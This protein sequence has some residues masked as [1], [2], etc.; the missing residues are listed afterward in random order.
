MYD[1]F[2]LRR[3]RSSDTM[4]RMVRESRLS[5]DDFMMP[6]FIVPGKG[7]RREIPSMPGV[8]QI[9][10]DQVVKEVQ[11]VAEFRIPGVLLFGTAQK[12][13][14]QASEAYSEQNVVFQAI[15][16]LKSQLLRVVIAADVCLCAY[17]SHGHCGLVE[18]DQ[19]LNDPSLEVLARIALNYARA[20]VDL[21]APSDMMDGRIMSIRATL[22]EEGFEGLPIMSYAAKFSSAFYGP[23]R[24]AQHSV[25]SFGN[26]DTYQMDP[27]NS[28]MAMREVEADIQE[29][30]DIVMVK[31]AMPYLDIIRRVREMTDTPIA[32]Y[33]VSGEYAMIK[34]AADRGAI[35][36]E[37]SII[38]S[39][40]SIKRAGADLI[41]TYFAKKAA[42]IL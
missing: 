7:V 10:V 24:D 2:R 21:I 16:E 30:A 12:K 8:F 34:A 38:E 20:G 40:G 17:T 23:F 33:Q 35:D 42:R 5:V 9:S 13:D 4:R 29:G 18:K 39:L 41:V 26:R 27:M 22:D 1:I 14:A 31:P 6:L 37:K 25:P 11:E 32:A 19:I 28:R 36:L 15:R 3:L